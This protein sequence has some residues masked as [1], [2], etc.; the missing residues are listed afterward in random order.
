MWFLPVSRTYSKPY[1]KYAL[2]LYFSISF[3][4]S[5]KYWK[6]KKRYYCTEF[7]TCKTFTEI[8]N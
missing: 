2:L 6:Q 8:A 3:S 7:N 1:I 4:L 5:P